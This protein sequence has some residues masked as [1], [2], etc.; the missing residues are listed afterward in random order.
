[1]RVSA[2][3]FI[4]ANCVEKRKMT[5]LSHTSVSMYNFC[6]KCYEIHYLQGIRPKKTKSS[7]VFGSAIDKAFNILLETK[8]LDKS[9]NEFN[10]IW[11]SNKNNMNLEYSKSDLDKELVEYFK[12]SE[13]NDLEWH[14]LLFKG[15]LFIETYYRE[16]LPKI[17]EVIS[18]QEKVSLKN[19][20]EDE[21]Y[22]A[23]DAI[24]KWEDNKIY[25]IDNKTSS[26][27]YEETAAKDDQQL[28][29]YYYICKEKY[30]LDGVGYI[31]L[32]KKINKN[33]VKK[34]N[35]CTAFNNSSHKTC[36]NE[37][38][39]GTF[40]NNLNSPLNALDIKY[41]R[42]G[43]EFEVTINPTV[44]LQFIFNK[45]EESDE[46]RVLKTFDDANYGISNNLFSYEHNPN[47]GKFGYCTY[48]TYYPGNPDFIERKK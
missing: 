41:K 37:I 17:K 9:L 28:P 11:Q 36:N 8:D 43:G 45:I 16:V 3:L 35:K 34:C 46:E 10:S 25:I 29:L 14:S 42:C 26:V 40:S 6:S 5:K 33:K 18:V 1:M 27:K 48:N 2:N 20:E 30:K 31:V 19:N 23:L 21:I 44:E 4:T 32:S 12:S 13:K 38:E 47:K 39:I 22:G 24:I 15:Q 7:L